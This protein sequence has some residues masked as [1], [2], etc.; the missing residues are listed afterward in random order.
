MA[1]RVLLEK[2]A[3]RGQDPKVLEPI[4]MGVFA[5]DGPTP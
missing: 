5:S 2:W 4:R 3:S 1:S